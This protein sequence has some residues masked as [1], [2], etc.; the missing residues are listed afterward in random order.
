VPKDSGY[1][2]L[3]TVP[4]VARLLRVAQSIV[5]K[6]IAAGSVPFVELPGRDYRIP[7][8]ELVRG[9]RSNIDVVQVLDRI[10]IKLQ[11]ASTGSLQEEIAETRS[12]RATKAS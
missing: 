12:K 5:R 2:D 9:L 3:L 11:S 1:P 6:W 4:E 7:R 10:E 8:T